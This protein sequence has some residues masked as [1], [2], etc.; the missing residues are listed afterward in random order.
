MHTFGL[1][2]DLKNRRIIGP[3]GTNPT[4]TLTTIGDIAKLVVEAVDYTGPWPERGGI[5][6]NT[7]T[8]LEL[9]KVIESIRGQ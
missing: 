6:G 5:N 4:M 9:E 1:Q 8:E 3:E 2:Y 7:L